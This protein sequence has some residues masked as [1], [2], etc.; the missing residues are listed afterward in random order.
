MNFLP[1]TPRLVENG[2]QALTD[3]FNPK[4]KP[5]NPLRGIQA[6]AEV[7]NAVMELSNA[8]IHENRSLREAVKQNL[9]NLAI[10]KPDT[11]A[12]VARND[13]FLDKNENI[14]D[15]VAKV[16]AQDT[17]QQQYEEA[18]NREFERLINVYIAQGLAENNYQNL[19]RQTV[20]ADIK[21]MLDSCFYTLEEQNKLFPLLP[22][23]NYDA[24]QLNFFEKCTTLARDSVGRVTDSWLSDLKLPAP[25]EW[26]G[27][28]VTKNQ[29]FFK[30]TALYLD[31]LKAYNVFNTPGWRKYKSEENERMSR[32]YPHPS[33]EFWSMQ[34]EREW[35]EEWIE[36]DEWY[37][38]NPGSPPPS[39]SRDFPDHAFFSPPR[40]P[41]KREYYKTKIDPYFYVVGPIV[42]FER[43]EG[44]TLIYV[45]CYDDDT[46]TTGIYFWVYLS[47]SEGLFRVFFKLSASSIIEKGFDYTQGT[48]VDFQL[49]CILSLYYISH[50]T[51]GKQHPIKLDSLQ[52]VLYFVDNMPY[53]Q[54][55]FLDNFPLPLIIALSDTPRCYVGAPRKPYRR[56]ILGRV[57][58][59]VGHYY[60]IDKKYNAIFHQGFPLIDYE[61][62]NFFS[63]T[64][65]MNANP[66]NR[67]CRELMTQD[68]VTRTPEGT[69][70]FK[71]FLRGPVGAQ[72]F[73]I[74]EPLIYCFTTSCPKTTLVSFDDL[75]NVMNYTATVWFQGLQNFTR[76][77]GGIL[78]PVLYVIIGA[79]VESP[80]IDLSSIRDQMLGIKLDTGHVLDYKKNSAAL[81]TLGTEG[82]RSVDPTL[83]LP[84]PPPTRRVALSGYSQ[85]NTPPPNFNDEIEAQIKLVK[86][87]AQHIL[88]II[89]LLPDIRPA[90][91][92]TIGGED[93]FKKQLIDFG[94]LA[95][96]GDWLKR[97]FDDSYQAYPS[98]FPDGVDETS[99]KKIELYCLCEDDTFLKLPES[100]LGI[101]CLDPDT[102]FLKTLRSK[103]NETRKDYDDPT[104]GEVNVTVDT[105]AQQ[106]CMKFSYVKTPEHQVKK[107]YV[108]MQ[109]S[110]TIVYTA[111]TGTILSNKILYAIDMQKTPIACLPEYKL[112]ETSTEK[113]AEYLR[114]LQVQAGGVNKSKKN[115]N[116]PG[117]IERAARAARAAQA[118]QAAP[119]KPDGVAK[120]AADSKKEKAVEK[121]QAAATEQKQQQ[122]QRIQVDE[123]QQKILRNL[124]AVLTTDRTMLSTPKR[125][126][127]WGGF[128]AGKMMEYLFGQYFQLPTLFKQYA[129]SLQVCHAYCTTALMYNYNTSR[130]C[131]FF[132]T[133]PPLGKTYSFANLFAIKLIAEVFVAPPAPGALVPQ[134]TL[135]YVKERLNQH[136]A[137]IKQIGENVT[138]PFLN[139]TSLDDSSSVASESFESNSSSPESYSDSPGSERG[140]PRS[141]RGSPRSKRGSPGSYSNADKRRE[142]SRSIQGRNI[143]L[144]LDFPLEDSS[145]SY[146]ASQTSQTSRTSRTSV[147]SDSEGGSLM[148]NKS[149]KRCK[150][151]RKNRKT[152]RK[153]TIK[154]GKVTRMFK[155]RKTYKRKANGRKL[156]GNNHKNNKTMRRYRRVRK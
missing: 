137:K 82:F 31:A 40:E 121:K 45:K 67:Y 123:G 61:I 145:S 27:P 62:N 144:G 95:I 140:S 114:K 36:C 90:T 64:L 147:S 34:Y 59:L 104:S 151:K 139:Y 3:L 44:R 77:L 42:D 94:L 38:R 80:D 131:F 53:L 127:S 119:P 97:K 10:D 39:L 66:D 74:S 54:S 70:I 100:P 116:T 60:L 98:V 118:A 2:L 35:N 111:V 101:R 25:V 92:Q 57:Q 115:A 51:G 5:Q 6:Q 76:M 73:T 14:N 102:P 83:Y 155:K 146:K 106:Y 138:A 96:K 143:V 1:A 110:S 23:P 91:L 28:E 142:R 130:P 47:K 7:S 152:T 26:R 50:Y 72:A 148:I 153:T 55:S 19:C 12:E 41:A 136:T 129:P 24:L 13:E 88:E 68:L 29:T 22:K 133:T 93:E 108:M 117:Q 81:M 11:Q 112:N 71:D 30:R 132:N 65:G 150:T 84:G 107:I 135:A 120:P 109:L 18:Q 17:T 124:H 9:D 69:N 46:Y 122:Q 103:F 126:A 141:K 75:L 16:V 33:P 113:T 4:S 99:I 85:K 79:M 37:K 89:K 56:D 58:G 149:N 63:P 78:S 32:V 8:V 87:K 20:M 52:R 105:L 86:T 49:Q 15:K 48:L 125:V 134:D 156:K 154:N 128:F 21:S 43:L